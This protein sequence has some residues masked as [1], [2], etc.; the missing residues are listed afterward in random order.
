MDALGPTMI[1]VA[2]WTEDA[3]L[4]SR[5]SVLC[6]ESLASK[7]QNNTVVTDI[8]YMQSVTVLNFTN[9][10]INSVRVSRL[11]PHTNYRCCLVQYNINNNFTAE[12]CRNAI[13]LLQINC[14]P[15]VSDSVGCPNNNHVG[16]IASLFVM[17]LLAFLCTLLLVLLVVKQARNG[18]KITHW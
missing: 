16:S 9:K 6:S 3:S 13:T 1:R 15:P 17:L 10:S 7:L 4:V 8:E 2:W 11:L 18:E 5:Y 12:V 14:G